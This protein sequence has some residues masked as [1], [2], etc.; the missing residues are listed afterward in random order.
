MNKVTLNSNYTSHPLLIRYTVRFFFPS[1]FDHTDFYYNGGDNYFYYYYHHN[2]NDYFYTPAAAAAASTLIRTTLSLSREYELPT[3]VYGLVR[4]AAARHPQLLTKVMRMDTTTIVTSADASTLSL[5][6]QLCLYSSY[7]YSYF[8]FYH[9]FFCH[10][11]CFYC[12]TFTYHYS[13]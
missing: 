10:F 12:T 6:L 11:Y 7:Y 2:N 9:Y 3:R 8:Y 4:R 13:F 1:M 5:L